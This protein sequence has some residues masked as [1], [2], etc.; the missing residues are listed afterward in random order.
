MGLRHDSPITASTD[1]QHHS[2][3]V[4][5]Q[6]KQFA[7][8]RHRP[9]TI[10]PAPRHP[11]NSIPENPTMGGLSVFMARCGTSSV[12]R[13]WRNPMRKPLGVLAAVLGLAACAPSTGSTQGAPS[14]AVTPQADAPTTRPRHPPPSRPPNR[15]SAA[16]PW[17]ART[18]PPSRS[19][20]RPSAATASAR[21]CCASGSSAPYPARTRS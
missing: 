8:S 1:L 21:R 9:G 6:G 13:I 18:S 14:A 7:A 20:P 4:G 2:G 15:T 12:F 17:P 16:S 10:A 19:R 11:W 5:I 3:N